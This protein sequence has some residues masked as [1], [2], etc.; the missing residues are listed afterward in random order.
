M[1]SKF[2]FVFF[3][4]GT[5][6]TTTVLE[7]VLQLHKHTDHRILIAT[8][9]N[10][11]ADVITGRLLCASD[12]IEKDVLRIVSNS[13]LERNLIPS[14]LEKVA[15]CVWWD[16]DEHEEETD[17]ISMDKRRKKIGIELMKQSRIVVSTCATVGAIS[18][19]KLTKG[20]FDHIIIEEGN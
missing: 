13:V 7:I 1:K 19:K 9:T 15:K 14:E 20:H 6:K 8:Q 17:E 3:A 2:S 16:I 5:G 4:I 12:E 10:S 18:T 11:A